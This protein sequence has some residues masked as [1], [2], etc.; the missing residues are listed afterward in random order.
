MGE[1]WSFQRGEVATDDIR[2][3]YEYYVLCFAGH[4]GYPYGVEVDLLR[5]EWMWWWIEW[6]DLCVSC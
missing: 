3:V 5:V 2:G 4:L 1:R 6:A